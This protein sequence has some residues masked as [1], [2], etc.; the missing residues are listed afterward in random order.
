MNCWTCNAKMIWGGDH[1]CEEMDDYNI[2]SNFSCPECGA[3]MLFY[4]PENKEEQ[5]T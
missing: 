5:D 2:V 3:F 1:D 4:H